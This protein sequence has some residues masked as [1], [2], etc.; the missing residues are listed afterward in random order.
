MSILR[1]IEIAPDYWISTHVEE[2]V[3]AHKQK[4]RKEK[5]GRNGKGKA[6][7]D[8]EPVLARNAQPNPKL[9]ASSLTAR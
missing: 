8:G 9:S 4:R 7:P 2:V 1:S 3:Y 6:V 5:K